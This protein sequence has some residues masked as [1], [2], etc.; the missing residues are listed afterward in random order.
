MPPTMNI[1]LE[2]RRRGART[3]ALLNRRREH[4]VLERMLLDGIT[5]DEARRLVARDLKRVKAKLKASGSVY[6]DLLTQWDALTAADGERL[7]QDALEAWDAARESPT[8]WAEK[9]AQIR[10][11]AQHMNVMG[12]LACVL[13]LRDVVRREDAVVAARAANMSAL[14]DNGMSVQEA[15]EAVRAQ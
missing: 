15:R 14:M 6:A 9:A 4:R 11:L 10:D 2:Q 7:Y 13:E 12:A 8:P 5:T 1:T 3:T